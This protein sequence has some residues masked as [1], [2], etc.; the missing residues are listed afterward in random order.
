VRTILLLLLGCVAHAQEYPNKPVRLVIGF[1][2]GGANDI[3]AR[4]IAPKLSEYLNANFVVE[5]RPGAN[6]ILGTDHV[7]KAAPDGYT[8]GL[9]GLSPLVMTAFTYAKIPYDSVNDFA[10]ITTVVMSPLLIVVHPALPARSLKEL[11]AL[12]KAQPDK[13]DFATAG[14]GGTTRML[15]EL[16]KLQ[17]GIKVQAVAYKGAAPALTELLG[18]HVQGMVMDLPVLYPQVK[19]GKLRALAV[20][21]EKRSPLLPQIATV[22]EQSL[23]AL[24]A[25]NWY[26]IMAPAKTPRVIVERL[27][28]AI[29]RAAHAPE[30]R[31][32]FISGGFEPMTSAS[33]DAYTAFLKQEFARWSKVA[34]A[35]D[36][37][38]DQ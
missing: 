35:A 4:Q 5:N 12:A 25:T 13:L 11:V 21:S 19:N 8:L 2:P 15:I 17:T 6:A 28:G 7:A 24:Q 23:P 20:T 3:I 26:A 27:H 14:A 1:P 33:P 36:I 38:A 29:T 10:G 16:M 34:K 31:E 32:K 37:K 18:G 9:A 22:A 30:L